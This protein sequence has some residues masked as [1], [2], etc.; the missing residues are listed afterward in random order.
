LT[1]RINSAASNWDFKKKKEK[2]FQTKKGAST[3]ALTLR[4]L[5]KG[6]WALSD[7]EQNQKE[8]MEKFQEV[9]QLCLPKVTATTSA[10]LGG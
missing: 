5:Q 6:A 8:L 2:Y 9:W 10:T 3:F 4:V 1:R 7:L